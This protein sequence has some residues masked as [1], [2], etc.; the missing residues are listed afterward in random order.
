MTNEVIAAL[1]GGFVAGAALVW[2]VLRLRHQNEM[3]VLQSQAELEQAKNEERLL[4]LDARL[5]DQHTELTQQ[6]ATVTALRDQLS[7]EQQRRT[8]AEERA[9]RIPELEQLIQR[10]ENE[11]L[12]FQREAK[13]L[14]SQL[15]EISTRLEEERKAAQEKLVLVD[16]AK[17][18]LTNAFKAL[19][20]DALRNNNQSFLDLAFQNLNTFQEGAKTELSERQKAI[21][22]LVKPLRESLEKVDTKIELLDRARASSDATLNKQIEMLAFAHG[23]LRNETGSLVKALRAPTVRGRWGEMQLKRVVEMAGMLEHCD[24]TTQE[25]VNTDTGRLRPDL[26]VKLPSNRTIV[27]DAK[28]PL[29]AYLDSTEAPTEELRVMKLLEHSRQVRTH[30]TQLSGKAYWSQFP[31]SP[32]FV[33]LFL[34]GEPFFSA[35]LEQDPSLIEY[36]A[37]NRVIIATPTTLIALLRAVGYGW[38]QEALAENAQQISKL[39]GELY[40]RLRTFAT[41]MSSMGRGLRSAV[42]S[43][44]SGIGS[45]ESRVI[46]SARKLR[47]MG[48]G[49]GDE[50][51]LLELIEKSPKGLNSAELLVSPEV[52]EPTTLKIVE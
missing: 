30:L 22:D 14:Q 51:P 43:Y 20:A 32:E 21:D 47:D 38:R 44:N 12:T 11:V 28:T 5:E 8:A 6:I 36:G 26:V 29:S 40:D 18:Q 23:E 49:S 42:E 4:Y 34:P 37:E 17:E 9:L 33:V 39:G 1:C 24:F 13:N 35:A 48:A 27:V 31:Q 7:T 45:L 41:H 2:L 25:S 15:A 10:R 19:S 46:V 16:Q 50:Q 52:D 3:T